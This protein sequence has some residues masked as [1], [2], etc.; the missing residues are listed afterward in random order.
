VK[1]PSFITNFS[2]SER[3]ARR[4]VSSPEASLS[5]PSETI[6]PLVWGLKG[7]PKRGLA[8]NIEGVLEGRSPSN[9]TFPFP[10]H[11]A[12]PP[13]AGESPQETYQGEGDKGDRVAEEELKQ[14]PRR[15]YKTLNEYKAPITK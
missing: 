5:T 15:I 6:I 8:Y 14:L 11:K 10:S 4:G 9:I 3:E 12:S 2:H 1:I 13:K 7:E